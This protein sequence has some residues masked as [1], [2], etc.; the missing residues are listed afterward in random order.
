[1]IAISRS[2]AWEAK[3]IGIHSGALGPMPI[4]LGSD[5]WRWEAMGGDGWR[6]VAMGGDGWTDLLFLKESVV[7]QL[8]HRSATRARHLVQDGEHCR[9]VELQRLHLTPDLPPEGRGGG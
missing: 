5:G 6:W 2:I 9:L 1:M 8:E 4:H 7:S 3:L